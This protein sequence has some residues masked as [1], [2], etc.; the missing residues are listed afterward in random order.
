VS[1]RNSVRC[2]EEDGEMT[3]TKARTVVARTTSG[4]RVDSGYPSL[5]EEALGQL[6]LAWRL[7]HEVD[8]WTKGGRISDG[9]DRWTG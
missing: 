8:D 2:W 3:E 7:A 5:T 6:K 1:K 9:F 4:P